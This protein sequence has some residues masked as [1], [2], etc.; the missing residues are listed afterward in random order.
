[1]G[2]AWDGRLCIIT[3]PSCHLCTRDILE[4]EGMGTGLF[5]PEVWGFVL[6]VGFSFQ[7]VVT[8]AQAAA[9]TAQPRA[10]QY[11][12]HLDRIAHIFRCCRLAGP[13]YRKTCL[14]RPCALC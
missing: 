7:A 14:T 3:V 11:T 4:K 2:P 8:A 9:P 5:N 10:S 1:V 6:F 13:K 12:R